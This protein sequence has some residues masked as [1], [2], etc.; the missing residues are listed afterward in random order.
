MRQ[1]IYTGR[2]LAFARTLNETSVLM[3]RVNSRSFS[4]RVARG[5]S[6]RVTIQ[7]KERTEKYENSIYVEYNCA[8]FDRQFSVL[9]NGAHT[10]PIY[11]KCVRGMSPRDALISVLHGMDYEFDAQGTPRIA[12]V[13]PIGSSQIW[14][15][16]V[17][18]HRFEVRS[19]EPARGEMWAFATNHLNRLPDEPM[20]HGFDVSTID[21]ALDYAC[22]GP[23][24]AEQQAGVVALAAVEAE[25]GHKV[26]TKDLAL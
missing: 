8:R 25:N 12:I 21:D 19:Y 22:S 13:A 17:S 23:G 24:F 16:F 7:P 15:G 6:G 18:A 14:A 26:K 5:H 11:E 1:D 4:D 2:T 10:D 20:A 3:Y 9:S